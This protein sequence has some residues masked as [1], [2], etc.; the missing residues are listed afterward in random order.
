MDIASSSSDCKFKWPGQRNQS[1]PSKDFYNKS[2]C[3]ISKNENSTQNSSDDLYRKSRS[4][5]LSAVD[6]D[7]YRNLL[8][9]AE[10]QNT[11]RELAK[12]NSKPTATGGSSL[13]SAL[14]EDYGVRSVGQT[15]E[16]IAN[17]PNHSNDQL[18]CDV[19]TF[20]GIDGSG[21]DL[22]VDSKDQLV[23]NEEVNDDSEDFIPCTPPPQKPLK[24][25]AGVDK[26]QKKITDMYPKQDSV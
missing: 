3:D 26:K 17:S 23:Q 11:K 13:L 2:D 21:C 5:L 10:Q 8:D 14:D 9:K 6:R 18:D 20:A 15:I 12:N 19:H 7:H 25:K 4:T 22:M 24:R 16:K 1:I